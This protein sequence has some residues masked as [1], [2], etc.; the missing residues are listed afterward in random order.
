MKYLKYLLTDEEYRQKADEYTRKNFIKQNKVLLNLYH[1][2]TEIKSTDFKSVWS[3]LNEVLWRKQGKCCCICETKIT[4]A[5]ARDIEH[6]RPKNEYWWLA[7]NYQNYYLTCAECNRK[8]KHIKFPLLDE[9]QKVNYS[10]RK[11][12]QEEKPLLIKLTAIDSFSF[13]IPSNRP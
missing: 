5:Y 1:Q 3:E 2:G 12:I 10:N 11:S 9:T 7:Y 4:D 13:F 8:Y 6:Y